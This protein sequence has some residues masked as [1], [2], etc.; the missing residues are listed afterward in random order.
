MDAAVEQGQQPLI[1]NP[2][3]WEESYRPLPYVF[4]ALLL[5]WM[6]LVV[7]WTL[8]TWTKRRWQVSIHPAPQIIST[9]PILHRIE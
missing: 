9:E 5:T 6:A 2:S 4:F 1:T 7:V 8:N 3:E